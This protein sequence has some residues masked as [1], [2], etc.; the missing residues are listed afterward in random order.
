MGLFHDSE[1]FMIR[2]QYIILP[3]TRKPFEYI[4]LIKK[5]MSELSKLIISFRALKDIHCKTNV[6]KR[7]FLNH[8]MYFI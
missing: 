6:H 3:N 1:N 4:S 2:N 8:S 7:P 5:Y